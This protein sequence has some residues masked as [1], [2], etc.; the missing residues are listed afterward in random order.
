MKT[1]YLTKQHQRA[2]FYL[3]CISKV[4]NRTLEAQQRQKELDR[5]RRNIAASYGLP[6][7]SKEDWDETILN[8][9]SFSVWLMTR[10]DKVMDNI[11]AHSYAK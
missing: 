9:K 11:N 5:N 3:E 4:M 6:Y 2:L 7:Y 8:L 10:Y 1:T